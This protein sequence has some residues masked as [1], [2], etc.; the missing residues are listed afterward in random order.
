[1]WI[2][3]FIFS[4]CILN[5]RSLIY[6]NELQVI[7]NYLT[8]RSVQPTGCRPTYVQGLVNNDFIFG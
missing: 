6:A 1:M 2:L 3:A 8:G 4:Q 5:G 7:L